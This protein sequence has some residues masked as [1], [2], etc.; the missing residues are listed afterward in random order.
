MTF[1]M[2][3]RDKGNASGEA[4]GLCKGTSHQERTDETRSVAYRDSGQLFQLR[5]R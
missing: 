3:Y 4:D 1:E 5:M 2:V